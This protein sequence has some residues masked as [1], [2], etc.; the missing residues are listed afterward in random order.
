MLS[1]I[2]FGLG[3]TLLGILVLIWGLAVSFARVSLGV[4]YLSDILGGWI[5]GAVL[6]IAILQAQPIFYKLF[7]FVF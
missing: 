5:I 2:I 4:H 1:V 3:Y 7:P 6:A